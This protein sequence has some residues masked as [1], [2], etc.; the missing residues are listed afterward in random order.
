MIHQ[1]FLFE[2]QGWWVNCSVCNINRD[3]W[4]A[5]FGGCFKKSYSSGGP[6]RMRMGGRGSW[7]LHQKLRTETEEG[8]LR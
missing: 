2:K 1:F 4:S 6:M 5:V 8:C 7:H 3:V